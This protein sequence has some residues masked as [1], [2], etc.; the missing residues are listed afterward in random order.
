MNE[1]QAL[2][3]GRRGA[4]PVKVGDLDLLMIS[5]YNITDL[6]LPGY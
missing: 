1:A 4:E 6:T 3:T 2:E 5:D